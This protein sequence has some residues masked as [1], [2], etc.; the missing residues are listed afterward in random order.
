M[1]NYKGQQ[2]YA[3]RVMIEARENRYVKGGLGGFLY[4][5]ISKDSDYIKVIM[6]FNEEHEPT[7][8]EIEGTAEMAAVRRCA[9]KTL[10]TE[11]FTYFVSNE[12]PSMTSVIERCSVNWVP[13]HLLG[14]DLDNADEHLKYLKDENDS[15][16]VIFIDN[17]MDT[18]PIGDECYSTRDE[19]EWRVLRQGYVNT[20]IDQINNTE[21]W[22]CS[23]REANVIDL[24]DMTWDNTR[25]E[26]H[27]RTI[28]HSTT[29]AVYIGFEPSPVFPQ[30]KRPNVRT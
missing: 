18:D 23:N 14:R 6:Q 20:L 24:F 27:G 5:Q 12:R 28:D 19:G 3:V 21:A 26:L 9:E 15:I 13:N 16:E 11:A 17:R 10:S 1:N 29:E 7:L 25:L 4:N 22:K 30:W 8:S 2:I